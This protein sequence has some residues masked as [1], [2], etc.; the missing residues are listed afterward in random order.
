MFNPFSAWRDLNL[1][2]SV[3]KESFRATVLGGP[4]PTVSFQLV[5]PAQVLSMAGP[6]GCPSHLAAAQLPASLTPAP[7][8]SLGAGRDALC[9]MGLLQWVTALSATLHQSV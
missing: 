1:H 9:Q 6:L 8:L 5:P 7:A 2:L 4:F 3:S